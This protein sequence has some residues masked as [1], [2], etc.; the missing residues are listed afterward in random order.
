MLN[1]DKV[2]LILVDGMRSDALTV[3]NNSYVKQLLSDSVSTLNAKTVMPSVTLPCHMSLFH[4]VPPQRHNVLSNIYVP[5]VRPVKGLFEQLSQNGKECAS[6]Y[7]WEELRDLSRPGSLK[8]SF[9]MSMKVESSDRCLTERAIEYINKENPDFLFLY[10]GLTDAYGH[11][12]GWM[13]EEYLNAVSEA[14]EC[15]RLV[16]ENAGNDYTIMITA[17]HGGHERIHGTDIDEDMTI[18]FII[19]SPNNL[20]FSMENVSILDYAPTIA[21][22]L[23]VSL[24]DEWEGNSLLL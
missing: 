21:S 5:Q 1:Q 2:I 3:C 14:V 12:C 7:N 11:D 8:H 4:S 9:Y 6:F 19:H 16:I 18:P 22:I 23:N 13:S 20:K 15:I 24:N 17:D 10:L